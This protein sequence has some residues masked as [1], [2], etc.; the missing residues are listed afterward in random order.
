M[1]PS[2]SPNPHSHAEVVA[3][4][5]KPLGVKKP[6]LPAQPLG[7]NQQFLVPLGAR[8]LSVLDPSL[9]SP[10]SI[11]ADLIDN[12]FQD[13]PFFPTPEPATE[14]SPATDAIAPNVTP[15][16][17]A[18]APSPAPLASP[19]SPSS[20]S[21]L[22]SSNSPPSTV[23]QGH[24]TAEAS[25]QAQ[26]FPAETVD[27][28]P[29]LTPL[30]KIAEPSI[31]S[32]T[33]QSNSPAGIQL[34]RSPELGIVSNQFIPEA[35][36]Q[37]QKSPTEIPGNN[38][39]P[40]VETAAPS[41]NSE[42]SQLNS[43]A[44]V[45]LQRSPASNAA[46]QS[47]PSSISS[48]AVIPSTPI[49]H[50][51]APSPAEHSS[52][53][54]S[55]NQLPT[56]SEAP[57]DLI[58]PALAKQPVAGNETLVTIED[59]TTPAPSNQPE[60]VSGQS[61]SIEI[62]QTG[63]SISTTTPQKIEKNTI[64]PKLELPSTDTVSEKSIATK[65]AGSSSESLD[66]FKVGASSSENSAHLPPPAE[67]FADPHP[68]EAIAI[69]PKLEA[70][71]SGSAQQL[72]HEPSLNASSLPQTPDLP[73][74]EI[75]QT[76]KTLGRSPS[77]QAPAIPAQDPSTPLIQPSLSN[78]QSVPDPEPRQSELASSPTNDL[79]TVSHSATAQSESGN[80]SISPNP[81]DLVESANNLASES[82]ADSSLVQKQPESSSSIENLI[83]ANSVSFNNAPNE[84]E[85]VKDAPIQK[86]TEP[87]TPVEN[88]TTQNAPKGSL[89][90]FLTKANQ[91]ISRT[92]DFLSEINDGDI[93]P[94]TATTDSPAHS[95][96]EPSPNRLPDVEQ[97]TI[98]AQASSSN[99]QIAPLPASDP[100]EPKVA[101]TA[102]D[103][104]SSPQPPIQAEIAPESNNA[105]TETESVLNTSGHQPIAQVQ[106]KLD[107]IGTQSQ[108]EKNFNPV[109][110]LPSIVQAQVEPGSMDV[111]PSDS[112]I[113][114]TSTEPEAAIVM[115]ATHA[116]SVQ[117]STQELAPKLELATTNIQPTTELTGSQST[118]AGAAAAFE[119]LSKTAE[120]HTENTPSPVQESK[121][122]TQAEDI[123]PSIRQTVSKPEIQ[124]TAVHP[125][126]TSQIDQGNPQAFIQAPGTEPEVQAKPEVEI[127]S[128]LIE[129][130]AGGIQRS[131]QTEPEVQMEPGVEIG[132]EAVAD[133]P[134]NVQTSI[135]RA[136]AELE[137][138]TELAGG[139]IP[140]LAEASNPKTETQT[141]VTQFPIQRSEIGTETQAKTRIEANSELVEAYT[142]EI[143]PPIQKLSAEP[144]LQLASE[145]KVNSEPDELSSKNIQRAVQQVGP[146]AEI[147]AAAVDGA[148]ESTI[149]RTTEP[150]SPATDIQPAIPRLEAE[151][152]FQPEPE[153][154]INSEST[155]DS[156]PKLQPSLEE[157]GT[158]PETPVESEAK[159]TPEPTEIPTADSGM[160]TIEVQPLIQ[161]S[162]TESG[163]QRE[164]EVATNSESTEVNPTGPQP[165]I[166]KSE[167]EPDIQKKSDS[168]I[169]SESIE[170]NRSELDIQTTTTQPAIQTSE[171]EPALQTATDTQVNSESVG[172]QIEN[173]QP[174]IQEL[175]VEL[176]LQPEPKVAID[177]DSAEVNLLDAQSSL[178]RSETESEIQTE[179]ETG[180]IPESVEPNR[181]DAKIELSDIQSPIQKLEPQPEIQ[182]AAVS[183][184]S[185]EI[186]TT[187]IQPAIQTQ[188]ELEYQPESDAGII[189]GPS[190]F[191][192]IEPETQ[193]ATIQPLTQ[194]LEPGLELQ[195]AAAVAA[196]PEATEVRPTKPEIQPVDPQTGIQRSEAE[197]EFQSKPE[198]EINSEPIEASAATIQPSVQRSEAKPE[199]QRRPKIE[200][201]SESAKAHTP[202]PEFQATDIQSTVQSSQSKFEIHKEPDPEITPELT[203]T[204]RSEAAIQPSATQTPIQQAAIEPGIQMKLGEG[205]PASTEN[206]QDVQPS[207]SVSISNPEIQLLA[208]ESVDSEP[209][210]RDSED[211]QLSV[212]K[213]GFEPEFQPM[214]EVGMVS[215]PA[216]VRKIEPEFQ[217][218]DVQSPIQ[219][220]EVEPEFRSVPAVRDNAESVE[221]STTTIQPTVQRL[222]ADPEIQKQS[223]VRT[224][225]DPVKIQPS[226]IQA[227]V[228]R[229]ESEP[230]AQILPDVGILSE[231]ARDQPAEPEI[232]PQ[233]VQSSVQKLE[234]DVPTASEIGRNSE[235]VDVR[236][237][238][239]TIQTAKIQPSTQQ[240]QAEPEVQPVAAA[241]VTPAAIAI[242]KQDIQPSTQASDSQPELQAAEVGA[243]PA[244]AN[245]WAPEPEIQVTDI[246]PAIQRLEAKPEVQTAPESGTNETT[247]AESLT[248]ASVEPAVT[249]SRI[250]ADHPPGN[251]Q[252]KSWEPEASQQ[253]QRQPDSDNLESVDRASPHPTQRSEAAHPQPI[254]VDAEIAPAEPI[255]PAPTSD[256]S[257]ATTNSEVTV[258]R[259]SETAPSSDSIPPLP[260]VLQDLSVLQPLA[261]NQPAETAHS[262]L[263]QA[264][265]YTNDSASA[266]FNP[267]SLDFP[268]SPPFYPEVVQPAKAKFSSDLSDG[269]TFS[270]SSS[271]ES[272]DV[273]PSNWSSLAELMTGQTASVQRS[274]AQNSPTSQPV[275][276]RQRSV[277]GQTGSMIQAQP[278]ES[279]PIR[280]EHNQPVT[281]V[282]ARTEEPVETNDD[283]AGTDY[284]EVVAQAIYDRLKQRLR[285]EQERHGRDYSGRLPW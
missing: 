127:N 10:H 206:Q 66:P 241:E 81:T 2:D 137:V 31:S 170:F 160:P 38:L 120:I 115:G 4:A 53:I 211:T 202:E 118:E 122:E 126:E 270:P 132:S 84:I 176:E 7:I 180:I 52:D 235:S 169:P 158:G 39:E 157:L 273:L 175:K 12:S 63:T 229:L 60:A 78:P 29:E 16:N 156:T 201:I 168:K 114:S 90:K 9:S 198:I 54:G 209:I 250:P 173:I 26:S 58:Q 46:P 232:Q 239:P 129:F 179:L 225:S 182:T 166:E 186:P 195:T 117:R 285:V 236:A 82:T 30:Q 183:S 200:N 190:E 142:A 141:T 75:E 222:D 14:V 107:S 93:S 192:A 104:P 96:I 28:H 258:Q 223:E 256:F 188:A 252:T 234:A 246:Q 207:V 283:S 85:P 145:V 97:P 108:T 72:D 113:A 86:Q 83:A 65:F 230:K 257:P 111:Q 57:S 116:E 249:G 136:E 279:S 105:L 68:L 243:I 263:I 106:Q 21:P 154:G 247:P 119:A 253:I 73:Q 282:I 280:V 125:P 124:T 55:N 268:S 100:F 261:R 227:S 11:Q 210:E 3:P 1:A 45:Q 49:P 92:I 50:A 112:A 123:Q 139:I 203:A 88:A 185:V 278:I 5:A 48:S 163:L 178:Q 36:V 131:V 181:S 274:P 69:Q 67:S 59:L 245:V 37:A 276:A 146:E 219:R 18:P 77:A 231:S 191:N 264:K 150:E 208:D 275:I 240:L 22:S 277:S 242:P 177:S 147:Q 128:D 64:Q 20:P 79:Q 6:L 133:S 89:G 71:A 32:E 272:T 23:P 281:T 162:G 284:L 184:V 214:A 13:S 102:L 255:S 212:Q 161:K 204:S 44:E 8:S 266:S 193:T 134:T 218:T 164:P 259:S 228:Q 17:R 271:G 262:P 91:F 205:S 197:P 144:E 226:D 99:S 70:D 24:L 98:Q 15:S 76:T 152:A 101:P 103:D 94:T 233:T 51:E 224:K 34:Q 33:S 217:A 47:A 61:G 25:V 237:T 151:S 260:R 215:E 159:A 213:S 135:R 109:S 74:Q 56:S 196:V 265:G 194:E 189:P 35:S 220:S 110:D 43:A 248:A 42:T 171:F 19:G 41:I 267:V 251:H 130:D 121:S 167:I 149:A 143:Q 27:N 140:E 238:E 216:Q 269:S 80:S 174:A 221:V 87:I 138:Q 62:P 165:S 199:N 244:S 254:T 95:S 148:S 153:L 187:S 155:G 40:F 172:I